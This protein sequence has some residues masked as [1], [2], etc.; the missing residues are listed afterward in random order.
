LHRCNC[1]SAQ[2]PREHHRSHAGDIA[3]APDIDTD[4]VEANYPLGVERV[5]NRL[6]FRQ[7][8]HN[9]AMAGVL[10]NRLHGIIGNVALG[11]IRQRGRCAPLP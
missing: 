2:P 9:Q 11:I 3:R 7:F 10:L 8:G 4:D 1:P 6:Y 5:D